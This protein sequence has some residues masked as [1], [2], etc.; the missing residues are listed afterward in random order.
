MKKHQLDIALSSRKN[1]KEPLMHRLALEELVTSL[2]SCFINN[3]SGE[4]ESEIPG[5]LQAIAELMGADRSFI[6]LLA[7]DQ[8][9][10]PCQF[11]WFTTNLVPIYQNFKQL[12]D[13]NFKWAVDKMLHDEVVNI[14]NLEDLPGEASFEKEI[15]Q[16]SGMKS[17]V[18]V[19]LTAGHEADRPQR[20][21]GL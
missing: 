11:E 12:S 21:P 7:E 15:W 6:V 20:R 3:L 18:W 4:I 13:T 14:P 1:L 9:T 5:A 16:A 19:P 2:S 17:L 10:L 8:K